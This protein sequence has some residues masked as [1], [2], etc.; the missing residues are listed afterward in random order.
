MEMEKSWQ[1]TYTV[2]NVDNCMRQISYSHSNGQILSYKEILQEKHVKNGIFWV[3]VS[4]LVF[5][6]ELLQYKWT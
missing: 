3:F 1:Y 4:F 6:K 2:S 5:K